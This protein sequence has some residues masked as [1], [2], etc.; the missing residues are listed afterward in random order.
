MAN[1]GSGTSTHSQVNGRRLDG[2]SGSLSARVGRPTELQQL[3]NKIV[4]VV[5]CINSK[6]IGVVP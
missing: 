5:A 4:V 1:Q 3:T 6:A 2:S